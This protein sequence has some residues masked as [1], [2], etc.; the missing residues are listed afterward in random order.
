MKQKGFT[1]IE[2]LVVVAVIGILA[3]AVVV[4]FSG[5]QER[6]RDSRIISAMG[7]VRPVAEIIFNRY[8]Y[9]YANVC[10]AGT[11]N[12]I[13]GLQALRDDI[14]SQKKSTAAISCLT[15]N[16][17]YCVSIELSTAG[18]FYCVT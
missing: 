9:S 12:T 7:Q 14:N 6:A 17:K 8:N 4:N 11:L 18:D 3:S 10:N 1:L 13:E 2:L 15:N 16:T 5:A